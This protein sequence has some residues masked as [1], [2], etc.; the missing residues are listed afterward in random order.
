[1]KLIITDLET[2]EEKI[3]PYFA[4]ISPEFIWRNGYLLKKNIIHESKKI[5]EVTT[6]LYIKTK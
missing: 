5:L 4:Y 3:E 1:M 6:F 2:G